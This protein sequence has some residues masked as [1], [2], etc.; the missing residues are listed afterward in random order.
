[1]DESQQQS[2]SISLSWNAHIFAQFRQPVGDVIEP[3]RLNIKK[4]FFFFILNKMVI[5]SPSEKSQQLMNHK[6]LPV[7][8]PL[9][10]G[11]K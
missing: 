10:S 7:H 1:M 3:D 2:L 8:G 11:R 5:I 4:F 6:E 9:P